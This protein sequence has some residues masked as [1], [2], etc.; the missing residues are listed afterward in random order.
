L[1][2]VISHPGYA[3]RSTGR[4][5]DT[6]VRLQRDLDEVHLITNLQGTEGKSA[7]LLKLRLFLDSQ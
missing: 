2:A 4:R 6:A 1:A 3:K 7:K 5:G